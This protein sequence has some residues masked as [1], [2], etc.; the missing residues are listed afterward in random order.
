MRQKLTELSN[1]YVLTLVFHHQKSDSSGKQNKS[2]TNRSQFDLSLLLLA[3]GVDKSRTPEK[4]FEE[5]CD[6]CSVLTEI[7]LKGCGLI[8]FFIY[9][10]NSTEVS[11]I[12]LQQAIPEI[13]P[14][15]NPYSSASVPHG[16]A[17][18]HT[19]QVRG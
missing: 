16:G 17:S 19:G 13:W 12:Q 2:L 10:E 14:C 4:Y 15:T 1:L 3:T 18:T 8:T 11:I 9:C 5:P 6:L 7:S